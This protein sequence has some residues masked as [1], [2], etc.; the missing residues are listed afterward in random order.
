M[1]LV[2]TLV[3]LLLVIAAYW[4]LV[5]LP[6]QQEFKKHQLFVRRMQPGDKVVTYG[7]LI[8]TIVMLESETGEAVLRLAEGVEVRVITAALT[9]PYNPEA[10]A[11][12]ARMGSQDSTLP[13][14][15]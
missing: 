10:L 2:G 6:R 12:N 13:T 14:G 11:Q 1:E 7:G 5:I 3:I 15:R 9:Q 8:G 4:S